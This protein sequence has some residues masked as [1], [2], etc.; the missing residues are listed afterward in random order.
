V[1]DT[2]T[3]WLTCR[4]LSCTDKGFPAASEAVSRR[5]TL[6]KRM[7]S[8]AAEC[9]NRADFDRLQIAAADLATCAND[10]R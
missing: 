8:A 10:L 7:G 5:A 2:W 6:A 1:D 4:H 3:N 9:S